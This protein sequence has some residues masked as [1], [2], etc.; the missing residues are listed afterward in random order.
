MGEMSLGMLQCSRVVQFGN[1]CVIMILLP[2]K[3]FPQTE[4]LQMSTEYY[5]SCI[6]DWLRVSWVGWLFSGSCCGYKSGVQLEYPSWFFF[7]W[8]LG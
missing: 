6:C 5:F 8:P 7:K 1:V 3:T 4:C 2:N